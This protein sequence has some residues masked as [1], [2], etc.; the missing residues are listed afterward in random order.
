MRKESFTG[1]H[2]EIGKQKGA[3]YRT[4]GSAFDKVSID[5][6]H[7]K[8]QIAIYEKFYP[9]LIDECRGIAIAAQTSFDAV[10]DT[11][12]VTP[13]LGRM[14]MTEPRKGCTIFGVQNSQGVFLGRNYDWVPFAQKTW[15]EYTIKTGTKGYVAITDMSIGNDDK[16][17]DLFYDPEDLINSDG[18][19]IGLTFAYDSG[20]AYG[21]SPTHIMQLIA[22]TCTT[23]ADAIAI[24][25]TVPVCGPKN[26][27]IADGNGD[28]A[29]VEHTAKRHKV[30]RPENGIL[31][32]TNHF[33]D[34]D[35]SYE[36]DVLKEK[37]THD[38]YI[39]Y[40]E[41]LQQINR[42][43]ECID[44]AWTQRLLKDRHFHIMEHGRDMRTIWTLSM[45]MKKRKYVLRSG[46]E[47]REL[48]PISAS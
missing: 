34:I 1:N 6:L 9:G 37:P 19:Y 40:Y 36:D 35:L 7:R 38:T 48:S 16:H 42:D 28:I 21:L 14:K 41:A 47:S 4:L 27:F 24:F 12:L 8:R 30:L 25:D 23:V 3:R 46:E 20:W 33:L 10:I 5:Q 32:H 13:L 31:I 2:L 44:I 45:D 39:R 43:K 15:E 18:F 26:F 11:L 22:E 29:A 17:P